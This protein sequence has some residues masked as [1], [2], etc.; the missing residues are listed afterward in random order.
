MR[1]SS[2]YKLQIIAKIREQD[3]GIKQFVDRETGTTQNKI[4]TSAANS[5]SK[6]EK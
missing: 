2:L 5:M 3:Q 1:V 6:Y 4:D